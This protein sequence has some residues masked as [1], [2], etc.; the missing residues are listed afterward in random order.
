MSNVKTVAFAV[1]LTVYA[2]QHHVG[3]RA[4]VPTDDTSST[5]GVLLPI[6]SPFAPKGYATD[7]DV[8]RWLTR[9]KE[10]EADIMVW[11]YGSPEVSGPQQH[12]IRHIAPDALVVAAAGNTGGQVTYPARDRAVIAVG[13]LSGPSEIASFSSREPR[14]QKPELFAP[15]RSSVQKYSDLI[16]GRRGLG[17]LAK[18][19]CIM[20]IAANATVGRTVFGRT[21]RSRMRE[22]ER[23]PR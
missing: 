4:L 2:A 9:A 19:E 8:I 16:I 5:L 18:Y 1:A 20:S 22:R 14:R 6:E 7:S 21:W 15:D 12:L 17:A 23:P 3:G 11:D 10:L 13:A